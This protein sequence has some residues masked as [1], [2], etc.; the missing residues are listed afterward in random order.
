MKNS[1]LKTL[2]DTNLASNAS[3]AIT[4]TKLR[5]FTSELVKHS[6]GFVSYTNANSTPQNISAETFTQLTFDTSGGSNVTSYAPYY[7]ETALIASNAIQIDG[8]AD[9]SVINGRFLCT[10]VTGSSNV[11]VRIEARFKN[12]GGTTIFT[13][14]F[15]NQ[16]FKASGSH[17]ISATGLFYLDPTLQ[18]GTIEFYIR[19]DATSTAL[20]NSIMLDIR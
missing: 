1:T 13:Y 17:T 5:E 4:A 12:S 9:G 8:I 15:V 19:T 11:D 20:W 18:G 7:I 16:S 10:V 14:P 2:Q 3:N 6:G